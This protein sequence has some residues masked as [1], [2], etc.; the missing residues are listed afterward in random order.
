MQQKG[1]EL[2]HQTVGLLVGILLSALSPVAGSAQGQLSVRVTSPEMN[3]DVG[4]APNIV[5]AADANAPGS[6]IARV[7]FFDGNKLIGSAT[8]APFKTMYRPGKTQLNY[9][10]SARATDNAGR[11]VVSPPVTCVSTSKVQRQYKSYDY[12][13]TA[14]NMLKQVRLWIP[15]GLTT[16]RGILVVSNGAGGDTRD[17]HSKVW[18]GEFLH[19][20]GFAFLG[21]KGF[22]SHVESL[23]VMQN[24]LNKIA[25]DSNHPEL[26]NVPYVTT[27]FS[28]GGGYASRLLV[29][30][31][32]RVIASVP[33]CSRLN[34]PANPSADSLATPA[35]IISGAMEER[36]APMVEPVL[37]TYRPKGALFGWM[38]VQGCGHTMVGQEVLA[39]PLLDTAIRLRYPADADVRNGAVRLRALDPTAGWIADNTTWKSGLT[40]IAP[41]NQF[42]G[43]VGKSSWLPTEEIAFI[44][45]AYATY[46]RP[47]TIA[48]PSASWSEHRVW[49]P[50]SNITIVVDD[51]RFPRWKKLEFYDGA[52]KLGETTEAPPQCTA[53]NL[54]AGFHVFSVLGTDAQGNIRPSNPVLA[55]VRKLPTHGDA[56]I[57]YP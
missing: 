42:K 24:A 37:E 20:H 44:Y 27:G 14:E 22:T 38:T 11:S 57:G 47:L 45:R 49:D 53:V 32:D 28:A 35:C 5:L 46:D 48:S 39:M 9:W 26:V 55:V 13:E 12:E 18:Y 50:G 29:D 6:V 56:I 15:D 52:R 25:R 19:L 51:S 16:V 54:A 10:I 17:W 1:S 23:R 3:A 7:E 4:A 36:L 30:V 31:P 33:V 8:Q 43:D 40:V 21:A 41:A 2:N 34:L